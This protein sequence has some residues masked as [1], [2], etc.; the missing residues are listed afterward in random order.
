M[1]QLIEDQQEEGAEEE[2]IAHF[3]GYAFCKKF[4]TNIERRKYGISEE[5]KGKHLHSKLSWKNSGVF[6]GDLGKEEELQSLDD[7]IEMDWN[8]L[9][10][11]KNQLIQSYVNT[12]KADD[13]QK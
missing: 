10:N 8:S 1:D 4:F 5:H 3:H 6:M 13:E 7:K 11:Q 2:L 12:Y 9:K